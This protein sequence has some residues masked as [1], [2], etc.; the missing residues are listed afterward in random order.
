MYD[1]VNSKYTYKNSDTLI[2]K[3][4]IKDEKKLKEYETKMVA[5]KLAILMKENKIKTF[6]EE[7]FKYIHNFLFCDVY[8]FA[9]KY[10]EENIT[11]ENF[12]FSDYRY[13]EENIKL[14]FNKI[15][16]EKLKN[17]EYN[18]LIKFISEIM[19]DLNVLHP[20]REGNGRATREFIRQLLN[21]IGYNINFFEIDYNDIL[22]VSIKAVIDDSEQINLLKKYVNKRGENK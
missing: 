4:D 2:N 6:D 19:T 3:L 15:N 9:G 18:E 13:I 10:R 17:M 11:K 20:F 12:L 5:V 22:N 8:D 7:H 16:I 1:S 14:I 21:E